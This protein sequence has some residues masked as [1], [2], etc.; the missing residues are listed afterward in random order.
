MSSSQIGRFWKWFE[1]HQED[2]IRAV[3]TCDDS[4]LGHELTSRVVALTP[5]GKRPRLN[6]EIGP[7]AEKEWRFCF[8]PL[9]KDNLVLTENFVAKS[10]RMQRWEFLAAKPARPLRRLFYR[11][12]DESGEEYGFLANDWDYVLLSHGEGRF[13]IDIIGDIP[14]QLDAGFRLRV[15]YVLVEGILGERFTIEHIAE[16]RLVRPEEIDESLPRT[17]LVKLR[18]HLEHL[19]QQG[20]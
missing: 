16:V 3:K 19:V 18:R 5:D 8:S 17:K 12:V 20:F 2:I 14:S 7:G 11:L 4:W 6:W 15:G 10:P 13:S 1:E 9:V